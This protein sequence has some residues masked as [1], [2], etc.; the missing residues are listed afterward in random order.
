MD[1]SNYS[2]VHPDW[3]LIESLDQTQ[4]EAALDLLAT[5]TLVDG[6]LTDEEFATLSEELAELP[7]VS[8]KDESRTLAEELEKTRARIQS[9][10]DHPNR[11]EEFIREVCDRIESRDIQLAVLRLLAIDVT[12]EKATESQQEFYYSVGHTWNFDDDTLEDLLKAAW[13]SHEESRDLE[14]GEDHDVPPVRG[15]N[16]A[17]DRSLKP[18]P[19]PF[20]Q[21]ET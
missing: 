21:R 12:L 18:L 20:S 7:F 6:V 5:A 13:T 4:A 17:R 15:A 16:W 10:A 14:Q 3:N 1:L 2:D 11:F 19:N 8:A 9:F